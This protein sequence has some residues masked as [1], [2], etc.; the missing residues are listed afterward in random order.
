MSDHVKK[1]PQTSQSAEPAPVTTYHTIEPSRVAEVLRTDL[2][3]G[4]TVANA[5]H[6]LLS[7]YGPNEL[8][9]SG[10]VSA[11]KVLL[12][13]FMN[14][15]VFVLVIA[16]GV[17]FA[18]RDYIEGGVI[19]AIII[20]NALIGFMQEFKAEKTMDSL[21]RMSSPTARVL[22][23]GRIAYLPT[24][25]VVPGDVILF[26]LGDIISADCRLFE[27][28]NLEV[29]EA[30]LT[31]ESLPVA[32]DPA[33]IPNPNEGIGDR[34]NM[35]YSST[36][37]TKGR[38]KGI[39]VHTGM[40]TEIGKIAKRL[41]ESTNSQRTPLQKSLDR[42][43]YILFGCAIILALV[44][45]GVNKFNVTPDILIYAI[46][47]AIAVIP[48]G[49]VAV[50]TLSMAI[51]VRSMAKNK[52]IVRQLSALEALG[53]V[54]NICS[55]KTGT[56]TQ[57]KMVLTRFYAPSDGY[58][59][60]TG[61]GI[62][63]VGEILME[64]RP[65][66]EGVEEHENESND[67]I[68]AV[69]EDADNQGEGENPMDPQRVEWSQMTLPVQ[70]LVEC[71]ALCNV[72][73]LRRNKK[74]EWEGLGDPTEIALQVFA[75]KLKHGRQNLTANDNP[76]HNFKLLYEH[77]FDS[78]VKRMSSVYRV[79]VES[80]DGTTRPLAGK[81][82][83]FLK[84]ASERVAERCTRLV[85]KH[86]KS[87]PVPGSAVWDWIQPVV[88]DM[89][90][91]GLR[92][93]GLAYREIDP[94]D[95]NPSV[96]DDREQVDQEMT[97]LGLVGIYDPPRAESLSSV[98]RCH[99][100]GITVHMLTGD[101]PSTATAIAKEVGILQW[102]GE[103]PVFAVAGSKRRHH[104]RWR[105]RRLLLKK[106]WA[107]LTGNTTTQTITIES[108]ITSRNGK[109]DMSSQSRPESV[110][111]DTAE[112]TMPASQFDV[113]S[114]EELKEINELPLVVA[115][116]SPDTKVKMIGALHARKRVVAMTGD[117]VNDS[118]SLKIA[119]IG[120][121]MGLGG[122]DVAKQ[123]SDI[124][125]TDDNFSTIVRAIAEGRR[126]FA[127]IQKFVL[128]L[129]SA[130]VAEVI[131]LV[132]GLIFSDNEGVSVYPM[133]PLQ[134]LFLNMITSS[135]PAMALGVEPATKDIMLRPPRRIGTGLFSPEIICDIMYYGV[136]MGA[137]TLS[138]FVLVIYG[139]GD[140][141]L[142][143]DCNHVFSNA[144]ELVFKARGTGYATLTLLILAH[145]FNCRTL[146]TPQWTPRN[147]RRLSKS[148]PLLLS[149]L[150]GI[151]LL[152]PALYIPVINTEVFKHTS[153]TWEWA[154]V[155]IALVIF[156][157][158]SELYRWAKR[159]LLQ[160]EYVTAAGDDWDDDEE[161]QDL[162]LA[163]TRS[164]DPF[165]FGT[166]EMTLTGGN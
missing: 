48:E 37:V 27:V 26:E 75:T 22:R 85:D 164:A 43:A 157:L 14:A 51:G 120:I 76:T 149:V 1:K 128:H 21:R 39:A 8:K 29:D 52:A 35:V 58:F 19:A 9:G 15:L 31:G 156:I 5:N 109:G 140:G 106:R 40:G 11:W 61:T 136:W 115:R 89:A 38:G 91:D 161:N 162:R 113:L 64:G 141:Q 32:K 124:V 36:L 101:H 110:V 130:N 93:L 41:T 121:A 144:C 72:A 24:R 66:L 123:A 16:M 129:M 155:L 135:P 3:E 143:N 125:L 34:I 160:P 49:M 94:E 33:V 79:P 134:I 44:V 92:V 83:A 116:C 133:S 148:K 131:A 126:I 2:E 67:T 57:S 102:S 100:A 71:A 95:C 50:V 105:R 153:L 62:E 81:T 78:S 68:D 163:R 13:Q 146:R 6:R 12:H 4:L 54:T 166:L 142:G 138:N 147:I 28:V 77:P 114:D 132:I 98:K 25:E 99:R 108:P 56:L 158:I 139:F 82:V 87:W 118:P 47:L 74:G 73:N 59:S 103:G 159:R 86:G 137:L 70:L 18:A 46:S 30:L 23:D 104:R 152:F 63:P 53:S 96:L 119:D 112:L 107:T 117:G 88:E 154:L 90:S 42:L 20:F 165:R 10:G 127:N 65:D 111:V 151:L 80:T 45:F 122:S 145:G 84:G 55:D 150:L 69:E 17:A 7:E 97:L 60:V